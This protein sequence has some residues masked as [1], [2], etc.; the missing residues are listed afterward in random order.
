VQQQPS[1]KINN[2]PLGVVLSYLYTA[3]M[4]PSKVM[5]HTYMQS[6]LR[7]I[8]NWGDGDW[9]DYF[10][11]E[12]LY[13]EYSSQSKKETIRAKWHYGLGNKTL[14]GHGPWPWPVEQSHGRL[15]RLLRHVQN[16]FMNK[17]L[18]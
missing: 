11:K 13:K 4:L 7:R 1:P 3:S 17:V 5:F 9:V 8:R 15:K 10:D 14:K 2:R 6:M 16:S 18:D 12:Y